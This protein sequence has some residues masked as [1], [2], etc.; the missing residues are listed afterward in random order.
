MGT[1]MEEISHNRPYGE[2]LSEVKSIIEQ[3]RKQAYQSVNTLSCFRHFF[4]AQK[5]NA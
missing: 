3:S 5:L 1:K 2:M 4:E